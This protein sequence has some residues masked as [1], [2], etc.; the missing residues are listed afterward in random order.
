[1]FKPASASWVCD[2]CM[3]NNPADKDQCVA[4][5]TPKPGS[6]QPSQESS[7]DSQGTLGRMGMSGGAFSLGNFKFSGFSSNSSAFS[8]GSGCGSSGFNKATPGTFSCGQTLSQSSNTTPSSSAGFSFPPG[9]FSFTQPKPETSQPSDTGG[10]K[11]SAASSFSFTAPTPPGSESTK[12]AVD[13]A[14]KEQPLSKPTEPIPGQPTVTTPTFN[15]GSGMP[16]FTYGGTGQQKP[17]SGFSF[18]STPGSSALT[19]QTVGKPSFS[20][21]TQAGSVFGGTQATSI[22]GA[23]PEKGS[24]SAFKGFEFGTKQSEPKTEQ[25]EAISFS[26]FV[27][28][29]GEF[30]FCLNVDNV[31]SSPSK[32]GAKSPVKSPGLSKSKEYYQEEERDKIYFEPV[33][34]LPENYKSETGKKMKR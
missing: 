17:S 2:S 20:T 7:C 13:S 19:S 27:K 9:G 14:T 25:K 1:M 29:Q 11:M 23:T 8:A 16:L 5:S 10:F 32:S 26:D 6:S 31:A 21:T 3:I 4:C 18:D 30:S 34:T 24:L 33:V 12:S 15:F 28:N 22:F